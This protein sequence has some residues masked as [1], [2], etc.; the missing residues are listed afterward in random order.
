MNQFVRHPEFE[1]TN[2]T[3]RFGV[4]VS[5]IYEVAVE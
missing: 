5:E 1:K 3:L 2:S 4:S